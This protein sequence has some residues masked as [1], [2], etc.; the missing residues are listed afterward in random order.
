MLIA[1]NQSAQYKNLA[2]ILNKEED[3]G[4]IHRTST[5]VGMSTGTV[6]NL[7]VIL[8][9]WLTSSLTLVTKQIPPWLIFSPC[10]TI[11]DRDDPLLGRVAPYADPFQRRRSS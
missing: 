6:F 11:G 4:L 5:K 8:K 9:N 10:P 2:P 7:K 1:T 3:N